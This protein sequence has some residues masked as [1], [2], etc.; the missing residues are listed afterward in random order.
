[1]N[2]LTTPNPTS[3][4]PITR[5]RPEWAD[6]VT[7][8]FFETGSVPKTAEFMGMYPSYLIA[9]MKQVWWVEEMRLRV[10]EDAAETHA[11]LNKLIA[12][13]AD[14]MLERL[15]TGEHVVTK[16]GVITIPVNVSGLTKIFE[17]AFDKRQVLRNQPTTIIEV[18]SSLDE[19]AASLTQLGAA[20]RRGEIIE[21]TQ[22]IGTTSEE[23]ELQCQL[24]GD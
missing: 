18:N 12:Q 24:L 14:H 20:K 10:V 13:S 11:K 19:L 21:E 9:C 16:D 23:A 7:R 1:M 4:P 3:Y 6:K 2:A 17:S 15:Q 22:A 8:H 5:V